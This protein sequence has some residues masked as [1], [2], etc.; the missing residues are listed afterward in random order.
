MRDRRGEATLG[1]LS[2]QP[3]ADIL[4]DDDV[5]MPDGGSGGPSPPATGGSYKDD[6]EDD[7]VDEDDLESVGEREQAG[8]PTWEGMFEAAAAQHAETAAAELGFADVLDGAA[9]QAAEQVDAA[10]E[11]AEALE[12]KLRAI[13]LAA[14]RNAVREAQEYG[15]PAPERKEARGG[16]HSRDDA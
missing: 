3:Y 10:E 15:L 7:D 9:A 16:R 2:P 4:M 8:S 13:Q 11:T 6:D 12:R 14:A 1:R 5:H